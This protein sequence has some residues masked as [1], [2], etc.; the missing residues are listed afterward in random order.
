MALGCDLAWLLSRRVPEST[1]LLAFDTDNRLL[2]CHR[3]LAQLSFGIGN[4]NYIAERSV[5][6]LTMTT[7][8][9]DGVEASL[10]R[11]RSHRCHMLFELRL[12]VLCRA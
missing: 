6:D 4:H 10:C 3:I 12:A 5:A 7:E 9:D 2:P 8:R 1:L 11:T